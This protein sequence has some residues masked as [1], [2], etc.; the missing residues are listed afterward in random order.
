MTKELVKI[1]VPVQQA[2]NIRQF[3]Q[4]RQVLD[5]MEAHIA[6]IQAAAMERIRVITEGDDAIST[7]EPVD[8]PSVDQIPFQQQAH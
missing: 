7:P 4:I 3:R 5:Q 8:P 1:G 2:S 6:R